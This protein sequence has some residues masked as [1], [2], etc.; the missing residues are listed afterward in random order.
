MTPPY[1]DREHAAQILSL[2]LARRRI[3]R[4][5]VL[6]I[7]RG[8]VSMARTIADALDGEFDIILARKVPHPDQPE[9]AV[10]SVGEDEHVW[11]GESG[12]RLGFSEEMLREPAQRAIEEIRRRKERL[13]GERARPEVRG[14]EII[15]VDDGIATGSTMEAA[16]HNVKAQGAKRVIVAAPVASREAFDRL[17]ALG[18]EMCV[19]LVP[20]DFYAVSQFFERF[21]QV[22]ERDV[23]AL[24][25]HQN[26]LR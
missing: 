24:F 23:R 11:L 15:L 1:R 25:E 7:P 6:G 17:Q 13:V 21:S 22:D 8:G 9:F 20:A 10:G 19:P 14:R 3:S 18:C 2:D 12:E 16:V 26:E 5:L 4:P